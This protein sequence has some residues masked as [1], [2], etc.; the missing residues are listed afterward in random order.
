MVSKVLERSGRVIQ[1]ISKPGGGALWTLCFA[2]GGLTIN[3][4]FA[5]K[6]EVFYAHDACLRG[7][8]NSYPSTVAVPIA[9]S[10]PLHAVPT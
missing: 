8:V 10:T 2:H 1:K 3:L 9:R 4:V 5:Y 6:H 7:L